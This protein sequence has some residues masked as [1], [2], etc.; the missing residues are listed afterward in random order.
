MQMHFRFTTRAA[1]DFDFLP[2]DAVPACPQ[3]FGRR[4]LCRETTGDALLEVSRLTEHVGNF[5]LG[6]D[7]LKKAMAEPG[8]Y[9]GHS[10]N[11]TDIGT[12]LDQNV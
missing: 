4:F 6:H 8:V 9:V 10:F 11:R 5:P 7:A 1:H 12:N 2:A 3:R